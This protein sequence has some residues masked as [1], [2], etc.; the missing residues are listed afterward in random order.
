MP[1]YRVKTHDLQVADPNWHADLAEWTAKR[2]SDKP[3]TQAEAMC[4]GLGFQDPMLITRDEPRRAAACLRILGYHRRHS[5]RRGDRLAHLQEWLWH[6]VE[7]H[8][9]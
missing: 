4:S 2:G 9:R 6:P 7:L 8:T 1:S 5:E 3:F